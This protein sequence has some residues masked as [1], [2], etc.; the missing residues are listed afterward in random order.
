[1]PRFT[2]PVKPDPA[3]YT[4]ELKQFHGRELEIQK[5]CAHWERE[6]MC[7]VDT[8][9]VRTYEEPFFKYASLEYHRSAVM[10][11]GNRSPKS[12]IVTVLVGSHDQRE[13][14][15]V[16]ADLLKKYSNFFS[17]ALGK[18]W[19]ESQEKV[20]RL[21]E[22]DPSPFEVFAKF[23]YSGRIY[24]T[25]ASDESG[26]TDDDY[27]EDPE[28]ERLALCWILGDKL[29]SV[30]FQDAS[31]DAII[32]KIIDTERAPVN[33]HR[34]VY[35]RTTSNTK[36]K[37]LIVDIA[38]RV[39]EKEDFNPEKRDAITIQFY[40]DTIARFQER[41]SGSARSANHGSMISASGITCTPASRTRPATEASLLSAAFTEVW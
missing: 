28:W 30:D 20:V 29:G 10:L 40:C 3:V 15:H 32:Q 1:M 13:T 41:C 11:T 33:L 5:V 37:Q 21:P 36:L 16:H 18:G 14:F 7:N 8:L 34:V 12:A 27:A 17:A 22:D 39:Y 26:E 2:R 9:N 19:L 4:D 23:L 24:S 38:A 6:Q 35:S 31:I 25:A